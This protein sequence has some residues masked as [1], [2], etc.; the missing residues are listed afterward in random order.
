MKNRF[1]LAISAIMVAGALLL[2]VTAQDNRKLNPRQDFEA[3]P[4]LD[5]KISVGAVVYLQCRVGTPVEFPKIIIT[6][7]TNQTVPAGKKVYWQANQYMK[8][9]IVLSA[10][11]APGQSV[12][13]PSVEA[14]GSSYAPKAWFLK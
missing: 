1:F 3:N 7:N 12:Y 11:L 14:K 6:N 9:N 5:P 10:P 4:S 8:G 2:S 13:T